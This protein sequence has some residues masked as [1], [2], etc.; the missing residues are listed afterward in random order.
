VHYG[1]PMSL[2]DYVSAQLTALIPQ[3]GL[4]EQRAHIMRTYE[5]ICRE[6]L[7]IPLGR[8]PPEFSRINADGTPFQLSLSLGSQRP[9]LQFLSEAG[10]PGSS[11]A[12]RMML[13]KERISALATLLHTN[14]RIPEVYNLLERLAPARDPEL[15][16]DSTGAFWIGASFSSEAK[17]KLRI[18]VNSKWGSEERRWERLNSFVSHFSGIDRWHKIEKVLAFRTKPLGMALTLGRGVSLS[19]RVYVSAYGN[20]LTYYEYLIQSAVNEECCSLFRNFTE[21]F[22]GE[23]RQYPTKSVVCSFG[24][25]SQTDPDF[26]FELCGHCIFTSDIQAKEKCL[27]WLKYLN[28]D[29]TTY[30][31]VLEVLSEGRLRETNAD[32]HCY[33][34]FGLKHGEAYSSIY[35]KPNFIGLQERR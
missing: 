10:V 18:Y 23:E 21:T 17:P 16:A 9:P 6:S 11:N 24:F 32:L 15:L 7:A 22:L 25:D 27:A 26:K 1:N 20:P 34:G 4:E 13:S 35:L 33:V 5:I 8:R 12:Y 19:G 28:L 14:E 2:Y 31:L 3:F 30:L 29:L